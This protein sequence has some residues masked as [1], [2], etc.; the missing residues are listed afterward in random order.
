MM[1]G[2]KTR[3]AFTLIEVLVVITII[4]IL[5]SILVL[6]FQGVK[7][8]QEIA[9]LAD[10][11]LALMQQAKADV[12]SGKVMLNDAGDATYLCEGAL[13]TLGEQPQFVTTPYLSS[14]ECDFESL[15]F[16]D[17]GLNSGSASVGSI[18]VDGQEPESILALFV[19]PAG[20][21]MLYSEDGALTYSGDAELR[22]E[23]A[24]YSV[25]QTQTA[26]VLQLSQNTDFAQLLLV[27]PDTDEE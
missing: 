6:N 16:E 27:D 2:T 19:P 24:T 8:K 18:E 20:A 4:G 23:S 1:N 9:L 25:D 12:R 10:K 21:L 17:Y 22:F 5:T 11:S 15:L 26:T 14:E 13:F 7:E 3:Q